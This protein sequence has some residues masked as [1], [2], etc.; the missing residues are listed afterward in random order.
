MY[1][2]HQKDQE[3]LKI[4]ASGKSWWGAYYDERKKRYVR[5]DRSPG[6]KKFFKRVTTKKIRNNSQDYAP[7]AKGE[8]K[9]RFDYWWELD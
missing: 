2:R 9:R 8:Y 7:Q 4:A 1:G 3:K 6:I 5:I